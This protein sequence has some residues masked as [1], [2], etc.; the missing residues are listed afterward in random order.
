MNPYIKKIV[1]LHKIHKAIEN[2]GSGGNDGGGDTP[3]P[4]PTPSEFILRF[5]SDYF[6]DSRGNIKDE[7]KN[8]SYALEDIFEMSD[9]IV[10][11][12]ID[13]TKKFNDTMK[14]NFGDEYS[15]YDMYEKCKSIVTLADNEPL[16]EEGELFGTYPILLITNYE[17]SD[18]GNWVRKICLIIKALNPKNGSI[19]APSIGF[20][21]NGD[22]TY[23]VLD[24]VN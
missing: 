17:V 23:Y 9:N 11:N 7:V 12:L 8:G 1:E 3:T 10:K 15:D 6:L 13:Y 21:P 2:N 18:N 20:A 4:T 5:K 24:D 16:G 14:E 19:F 22:G